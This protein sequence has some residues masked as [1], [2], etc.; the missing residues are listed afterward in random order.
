MKTAPV[1]P[2]TDILGTIQRAQD[3]LG[4]S[5]SDA[6]AYVTRLLG[7]GI[8]L[9]EIRSWIDSG[10]SSSK[11]VLDLI[12]LG[13]TPKDAKTVVDGRRLGEDVSR[14]EFK[15]ARSKQARRMKYARMRKA[16]APFEIIGEAFAEEVGAPLEEIQD[17]AVAHV[18]MRWSNTASHWIAETIKNEYFVPPRRALSDA[19]SIML[20]NSESLVKSCLEGKPYFVRS[21]DR[22]HVEDFIQAMKPVTRKVLEVME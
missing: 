19:T 7:T 15:Q 8:F 5:P 18:L 14:N 9:G 11:A 16:N 20:S 3:K 6:L 10:T 4:L 12:A 1:L 22:E 2:D 13:I 17:D 21:L